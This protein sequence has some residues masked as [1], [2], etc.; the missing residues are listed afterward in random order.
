MPLSPKT[1][2]DYRSHFSYEEAFRFII[3]VIVQEDDFLADYIL[4]SLNSEVLLPLIIQIF[5]INRDKVVHST[6][7]SLDPR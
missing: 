2:V 7:L 3:C 4:D 1:P 6:T 5:K